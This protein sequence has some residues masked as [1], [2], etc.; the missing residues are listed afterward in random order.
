MFTYEWDYVGAIFETTMIFDS[1]FENF[2]GKAKGHYAHTWNSASITSIGVGWPSFD[3]SWIP[4]NNA[5][6]CFS[7]AAATF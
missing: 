3:M 7:D 5:F 1:S 4:E 2:H 6:G